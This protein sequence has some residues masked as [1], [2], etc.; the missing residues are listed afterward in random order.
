MSSGTLLPARSN[1]S[2]YSSYTVSS[3]S[4]NDHY[5]T[6]DGSMS[7]EMYEPMEGDGQVGGGGGGGSAERAKCT[8]PSPSGGCCKNDAVPGSVFCTGHTCSTAGCTA[9][10]SGR[11]AACP[12]HSMPTEGVYTYEATHLQQ[13]QHHT[14]Y[15]TAA[16]EPHEESSG[17]GVDVGGGGQLNE[18]IGL[19]RGDRRDVLDLILCHA[20]VNRLLRRHVAATGSPVQV[21]NSVCSSGADRDGHHRDGG[22]GGDRCGDRCG[23]LDRVVHGVC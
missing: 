16:A 15:A 3:Y 10:K 2:D 4:G 19:S 17:V 23:R 13:P 12:A 9:G 14:V 20:E 1:K 8:R 5:E 22:E 7:L 11:E 6:M 18:H 21:W